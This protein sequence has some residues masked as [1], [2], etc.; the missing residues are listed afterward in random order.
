MM[1]PDHMVPQDGPGRGLSVV[2][3]T[4]G[5]SDLVARSLASLDV[6][7]AQ[8]P[9]GVPFD[10]VVVDDSA[11]Q[12]RRRIVEACRELPFVTFVDGPRVVAAKRNLGVASAAA[13]YIVFL[14][15][16]CFASP[17]FLRAHYV[18]GARST[19]ADGRPI[20][21]VAGPT[22][23]DGDPPDWWWRVA[24][25][26]AIYDAPYNWPAR[27][28]EV[29][30]AATNNLAVRRSVFES[31]GGFD[32]NTFTV[33]GGED[34]ELCLRL[35]RHGYTIACSPDALVIHARSHMRG[36][37]DMLAKMVLYG[38]STAYITTRHP[39]SAEFHA[40]PVSFLA[41]FTLGA[42]TVVGVRRALALGGSAAAAWWLRD[43]ARLMSYRGERRPALAAAA[44][45]MEWT[46]DAGIVAEAVKRRDPRWLAKRFRFFEASYF[47]PLERL[48][49]ART[50]R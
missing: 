17:A 41:A 25:F 15:S 14:D 28:S 9:A 37:R 30:W 24:D 10:V 45:L 34:V 21:A 13:D 40:N 36:G 23:L 3:P 47:R 7:R 50:A 18:A 33:V 31:L 22:V 5:R 11:G 44:V 19:T 1:S 46:F 8:L 39:D 32:E 49:Q 2:I 16:D 27:H 48:D 35:R 4:R 38:R 42:S 12:E 29:Y 20:G 43:A 26:S 6:A